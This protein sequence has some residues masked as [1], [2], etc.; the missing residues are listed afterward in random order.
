MKLTGVFKGLGNIGN[1]IEF[2]MKEDCIPV[3]ASR[4]IPIKLK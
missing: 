4:K 2:T 3:V 1:P